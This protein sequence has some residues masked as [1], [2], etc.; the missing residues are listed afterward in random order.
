MAKEG[1]NR[2][3]RLRGD[4]WDRRR[5]FQ[6]RF[7]DFNGTISIFLCWAAGDKLWRLWNSCATVHSLKTKQVKRSRGW[8][9]IFWG[10]N[11]LWN[12]TILQTWSMIPRSMRLNTSRRWTM[13]LNSSRRCSP[14][15]PMSNQVLLKASLEPSMSPPP[16]GPWT[17]IDHYPR[18]RT[19]KE[20]ANALFVPA[21]SP[22]HLPL[23]AF[24]SC[25]KKAATM[26]SNICRNFKLL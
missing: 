18:E 20:N 5:G 25:T 22:L 17:E 2:S 26:D 11:M 6:Q 8:L 4:A 16:T 1:K 19:A 12:W 23:R 7:G 15:R 3:N 21:N 14:Y 24:I 9:L 10:T 13:G